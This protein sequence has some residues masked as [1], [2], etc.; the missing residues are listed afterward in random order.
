MWVFALAVTEAALVVIV[1]QSRCWP[2]SSSLGVSPRGIPGPRRAVT[3]IIVW[4]L[5]CYKPVGDDP[6]FLIERD[7][8]IG[9]Q[10]LHFLVRLVVLTLLW[11]SRLPCRV[12]LASRK[13]F[14]GRLGKVTV[15]SSLCRRSA[16]QLKACCCFDCLNP[17]DQPSGSV[18]DR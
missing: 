5:V 1:H 16:P 15:F 4:N 7:I 13:E 9:L 12:G 18:H 14:R 3:L 6:L 2:C 8:L 11:F 17:S 10:A